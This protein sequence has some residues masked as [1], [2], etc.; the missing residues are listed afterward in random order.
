MCLLRLWT[1]LKISSDVKRHNSCPI[2]QCNK[3]WNRISSP[4]H[5]WFS[6][7]NEFLHRL[8]SLNPNLNS[9]LQSA[10]LFTLAELYLFLGWIELAKRTLHIVPLSLYFCKTAF[11]GLWLVKCWMRVSLFKTAL[12]ARVALGQP[13]RLP[14]FKAPSDSSRLLC[15]LWWMYQN[16]CDS[17]VEL[18]DMG[19]SAILNSHYWSPGYHQPSP[20]MGWVYF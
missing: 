5:H 4:I 14:A 16:H 8:H 20:G 15:E 11:L 17:S 19:L 13:R 2:L 3:I 10:L 6:N 18:W 12:Y 9:E 1:C 7:L